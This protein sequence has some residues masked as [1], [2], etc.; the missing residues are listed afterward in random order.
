MQSNQVVV[1]ARCDSGPASC[2]NLASEWAPCVGRLVAVCGQ[3]LGQKSNR[4][5]FHILVL[6]GVALT[7]NSGDANSQPCPTPD[8]PGDYCASLQ[9]TDCLGGGSNE[10]CQP[11]CVRIMNCTASLCPDI[12]ECAC[13]EQGSC[14]QITIETVATQEYAL[15]CLGGCNS[16]ES[17]QPTVNGVPQGQVSLLVS[18]LTTFDEVC[19][20]CAPRTGPDVIVGDLDGENSGIPGVENYGT[21]GQIAGFSIGTISCNIGDQ[22]LDWY[23]NNNQHPVIAQNM[24]RLN[25]G[26]FEHVGQS[27]LKHG[28]VALN[29]NL[30]STC[31]DPGNDPQ[32]HVDC[33]DPYSAGLNG[34]QVYLGPK[35]EVNAHTGDF[36][37]PYTGSGQTGDAIYKRLQVHTSDLSGGGSFFVEGH[38]V[39]PDDAAA[40]NQSNN[41]SYRPVTVAYNAANSRWEIAL[42]GTTH[43]EEP[44]IRAWKDADPSVLE[45]DIHVPGEGLFLLAAKTAD[46]NGGWYSYEYAVQNL[47]SDQSARP[48]V[49]LCRRES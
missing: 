34:N 29:Q 45:T 20:G 7:L 35:R 33:S 15:T 13:V 41:A 5:R 21:V 8:P 37:Y 9:Q 12:I 1:R 2:R 49:C 27:W 31:S 11:R 17:C 48:S 25:N 26:R 30:C 6:I 3:Q 19:C 36:P 46:M 28:L 16:P 23:S 47:N 10:F 18:S 22:S 38:Y 44:A 42:T 24:F 4:P 40:G 32:L 39:T 14:G 43:R